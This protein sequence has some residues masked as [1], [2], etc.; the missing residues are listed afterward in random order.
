[1]EEGK[2]FDTFCGTLE[3]CA[4]E[5]LEGNPYPG[6]ELD[7]FALGVTL[8]T[9]IFGENPF[10]D[11]EETISGILTPPFDVSA[12]LSG[13]VLWFSCILPHKCRPNL[14]IFSQTDSVDAGAKPRTPCD[15]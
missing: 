11:V 10:F 15:D 12:D 1:M 9:L 4:P 6:P 8:Y 14:F 3:Y 13:C 7:L 5:V 2:L